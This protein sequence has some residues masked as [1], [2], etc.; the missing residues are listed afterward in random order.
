M[1]ADVVAVAALGRIS[2]R[3]CGRFGRK[4]GPGDRLLQ[5]GDRVQ[6]WQRAAPDLGMARRGW[7]WAL[8]GSAPP[9][10][11]LLATVAN[12]P[13]RGEVGRGPAALRALIPGQKGRPDGRPRAVGDARDGQ[14]CAVSAAMNHCCF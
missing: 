9:T 13:S 12:A 10:V 2:V 6:R 11:V 5:G 4:E 1:R 14:N 7:F 8:Y 3:W